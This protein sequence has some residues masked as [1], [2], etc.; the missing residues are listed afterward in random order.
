MEDI[1]LECGFE[2]EALRFMTESKNLSCD[3]KKSC[4]TRSLLHVLDSPL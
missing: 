2:K 1:F 4:P 3:K